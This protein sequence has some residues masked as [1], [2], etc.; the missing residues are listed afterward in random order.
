MT[1][2]VAAE[3]TKN[4]FQ[5]ENKHCFLFDRTRINSLLFGGVS[6]AYC[7][8]IKQNLFMVKFCSSLKWVDGFRGGG[9]GGKERRDPTMTIVPS[10]RRPKSQYGGRT[11]FHLITQFDLK[12]KETTLALGLTR[13]QN[14]QKINCYNLKTYFLTASVLVVNNW[15]AIL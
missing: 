3:R 14:E 1:E 12:Y 10:K 2:N 5:A 9:R 13:V 4:V 7:F 6:I 11:I 15:L 8:I